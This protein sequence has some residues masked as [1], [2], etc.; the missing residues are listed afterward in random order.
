MPTQKKRHRRHLRPANGFTLIELVVVLSLISVLLFFSIPRFGALQL[1]DPS[2]EASQWIVANVRSLKERSLRD[3]KDYML[4][5]GIDTGRLWTTDLSIPEED[6]Q[7]AAQGGYELSPDV[8]ILDVEY[9]R[10]GILSSGVA[11][12][13]FS[14]KGYSDKAV[15]HMEHGN[16]EQRSFLI[17]PFLPEVKVLDGY[18]GLSE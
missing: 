7:H 4:H 15:I 1:N 3:N 10:R 11:D 2:R 18:R 12:I 5:V 9:P 17:E 14:A 13:L 8:K 6:R 16:R